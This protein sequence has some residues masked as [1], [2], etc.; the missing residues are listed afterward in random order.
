MS[1]FEEKV[2]QQNKNEQEMLKESF[3]SLEAAILS[4]NSSENI[5]DDLTAT[6]KAVDAIL[7]YYD[8]K[9]KKI[10]SYIDGFDARL[11]YAM[12]PCGIMSRGVTLTEKWYRD[13]FMPIIAFTKKDN[14]PVALIPNKIKGYTYHD[15]VSGTTVHLNKFTATL[16]KEEAL[17]FYR[18]LPQENVGKRS[19]IAYINKCIPA[20]DY[21]LAAAATAAVT[22]LG[23]LLPRITYIIAGKIVEDKSTMLL[24]VI[25]AFLLSVLITNQLIN[26]VKELII[27]RIKTKVSV[28]AEAAVMARLILLPAKFFRKY[29][30]GGLYSR[31]SGVP[32]LCEII[33]D[34]LFSV[35]IS[36]LLSLLFFGQIDELT[37][38]LLIPSLLVIF[39]VA[40]LS[41]F[42]V[43]KQAKASGRRIERQ[44]E[45]TGIEYSLMAGVQKIKTSGSE[46]RVFS[47]WADVY[48][49]TAKETYNPP[50]Y[51]KIYSVLPTIVFLFGTILF[52]FTAED[53]EMISP[54]KFIAF[55]AAFGI[56]TTAADSLSKAALSVADAVPILEM[57]KPILVETPENSEEKEI[58][59]NLKG[60]IDINNLS[61]G[62]E[63]GS[64]RVLEDFSLHIKKGDYVAI[65]GKSGSGKSTLLR[66][67]LGFENP[68]KGSIL[69][70]GKEIR[71]ID[72]KSLRRS[73]GTVLQND[74]LVFGD[75]YTNITFHSPWLTVEDAWRAAEIAGI[76]DDIRKMS[77]G[78]RT[79]VDENQGGLSGGQK[80]RILIARAIVLNPGIL[81]FDEAT[82]ALD[83][84]TQK[85]VSDALDTLDCTRVVIAHRLS[86]VQNCDRILVM[87]NGK[88]VEQGSYDELIKLGGEFAELVSRQQL[89][90]SV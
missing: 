47:R 18:P 54:D 74:A 50:F 65:V 63:S 68:E 3:Q 88:I 86:T 83:N 10:P 64:T 41:V 48:S 28:Q 14:R 44:A 37:P 45:Q 39:T 89:D 2:K 82:S 12:R 49:K 84:I 25:S 15:F 20:V 13:S 19:M 72:L 26:T 77:M 78:M 75:I 81:F 16:F 59:T 52:Y 33:V 8:K 76:A 21:V 27:N 30:S 40:V 51:L 69:Y 56:L 87:D 11:E 5:R 80:Q 46:K 35:V 4:D 62:Y 79:I 6:Q 67:L 73:I 60:N 31:I 70:D 66:L 22:L 90:K 57:V 7:G 85:Q 23:L 17:C 9:T 53:S 29:S 34:N 32:L 61:F 1:Q 36:F 58:I 71:R 55:S 24:Y 43:V 38:D 42:A